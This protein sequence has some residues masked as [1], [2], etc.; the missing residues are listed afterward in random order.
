MSASAAPSPSPVRA[1]SRS[2]GVG[3]MA[4]AALFLTREVLDAAL[5][6]PPRAGGDL[7]TWMTAHPTLLASQVEVLFFALMCLIPAVAGLHARLARASPAWAAV[8]CGTVAAVI[9]VLALIDIVQ[10]RL[11]FPVFGLGIG[12]PA[13]AEFAVA[14][15]YGGLHAV[16]LMLGC[17]IAALTVAMRR[18]DFAAPVMWSGPLVAAAAVLNGYPWLLG[19]PTSLSLQAAASAWWAGVGWALLHPDRDV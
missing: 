6:P 17:A 10:G 18:S 8:G 4:F 7:E 16:Q 1:L 5:G 14:V 15:Y 19:P 9:P 2:G 11:A 13:V 12:T 3:L